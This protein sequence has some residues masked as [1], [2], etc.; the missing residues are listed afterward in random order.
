[1]IVRKCN[2]GKPVESICRITNYFILKTEYNFIPF[3][4]FTSLS[5]GSILLNKYKQT[6]LAAVL[7]TTNV[8]FEI[9]YINKI[10][11]QEVGSYLYYYPVIV[12]VVLLSNPKARDKFAFVH[13]IMCLLFFI[14]NLLFEMPSWRFQTLN[15]EQIRGMWLLNVLISTTVTGTIVYLLTRLIAN[16]NNEII[17]QNN[18]LFKAK[19]EINVSLKE[20]E[21][22]LAELNHRVKNNLAIISGLLN[23]QEGSINNNEAKKI[24]SDSKNRI[25]S[26]ALVHKM[27]YENPDLKSID[28]GKYVSDLMFELFNGYNIASQIKIHKNFDQIILPVNKSIPLGLILNEIITNSIKYVYTVSENNEGVFEISMK[29][30]SNAQYICISIND[31]GNGFPL[32]FN[33]ELSNFSLGIFLIKSLAEQIDGEVKFANENGAKIE[34]RFLAN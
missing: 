22:L 29:L 16:Q 18:D 31:H 21:V 23:L 4:V 26:M 32:D 15:S 9:F 30:D 3:V 33:T 17:L 13:F 12:S 27:L 28:L 8:N 1:M 14:G 6:T 19:E 24:I 10:Y 34:L 20:K 7:F 25:N 11:P 2:I 5:I